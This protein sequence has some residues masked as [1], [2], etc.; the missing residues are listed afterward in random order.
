MELDHVGFIAYGQAVYSAMPSLAARKCIAAFASSK[1]KPLVFGVCAR[2][3]YVHLEGEDSV[4]A[5][6]GKR[7]LL[8]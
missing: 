6:N 2:G 7:T 8:K 3:R 4:T 1:A 5:P